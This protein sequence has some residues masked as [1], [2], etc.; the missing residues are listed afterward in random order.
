M[1]NRVIQQKRQKMKRMRKA[2]AKTYSMR[3]SIPAEP[4]T[5]PFFSNPLSIGSR[6]KA[7]RSHLDEY[8]LSKFRFR[9]NSNER[10]YATYFGLHTDLVNGVAEV[11]LARRVQSRNNAGSLQG[12]Q[13][14]VRWI[15]INKEH[16][17]LVLFIGGEI[18]FFVEERLSARGERSHRLSVEYGTK[19][20]AKQAYLDGRIIWE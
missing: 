20:R 6:T 14:F 17:K 19:E 9:S 2:W 18:N 1:G 12:E 10:I 7:A 15:A 16:H 11:V 8:L 13:R 5:S 3:M 4:G